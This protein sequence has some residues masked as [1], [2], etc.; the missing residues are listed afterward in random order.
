MRRPGVW[1]ASRTHTARS[2]AHTCRVW[3]PYRLSFLSCPPFWSGAL[4][5]QLC[6]G[7][8]AAG[9][10]EA[11]RIPRRL[12]ALAIE[13]M[14]RVRDPLSA[15]LD[16]SFPE[17]SSA[18][19]ERETQDEHPEHPQAGH[20]EVVRLGAEDPDGAGGCAPISCPAVSA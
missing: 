10:R 16:P 14:P 12:A 15:R 8:G 17:G 19:H 4:C 20:R 9:A 6:G 7:R 1:A 5:P 13:P 2:T 11:S 18:C 3:L